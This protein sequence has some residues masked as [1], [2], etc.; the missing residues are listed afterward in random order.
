MVST[1]EERMLHQLD[2]LR[3]D[4]RA[5]SIKDDAA[6]GS[7]SRFQWTIVGGLSVIVVALTLIAALAGAWMRD[8]TSTAIKDAMPAAMEPIRVEVQSLRQQMD[9]VEK[10]GAEATQRNERR[11][12]A[13]EKRRGYGRR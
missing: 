4:L 11:I 6:L 3:A 7:L 2:G 8:A 10:T 12:E 9:R 1:T 13:L 5:H